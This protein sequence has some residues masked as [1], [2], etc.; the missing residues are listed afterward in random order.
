MTTPP[1]LPSISAILLLDGDGKR[2][3]SKYYNTFLL[4]PSGLISPETEGMR[5]DFE[6][7][8]HKKTRSISAK[9]DVEVTHASGMTACFK[10]TTDVKVFIIAPD[11]ESE[12]GEERWTRGEERRCWERNHWA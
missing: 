12:L 1:L 4:A 6:K 10:G 2:L 11:N 3:A 7:S 8:L 5:Q 9:S